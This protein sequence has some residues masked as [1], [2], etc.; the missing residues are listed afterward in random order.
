MTRE[1]RPARQ[2]KKFAEKDI[3]ER[4]LLTYSDM[5]TL[6]LGLFIIMYSI[7]NVDNAK[8]QAVAGIIRGG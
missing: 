2:R 6:L 5:I 8:L 7:S 1:R 3:S 4:W